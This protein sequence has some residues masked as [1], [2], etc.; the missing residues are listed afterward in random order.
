MATAGYAYLNTRV[1]VLAARLL[2]PERLETWVEA[3]TE[4]LARETG[5]T[6]IGELLRRGGGSTV[7]VEQA[8]LSML[9]ADLQ[10]LT[11][12]TGPADHKFLIYSIQWFELPNLK[13][14]FR[15]KF[16]G[17]SDQAIREHLVNT[18]PFTTLPVEQLLATEDPA[19]ML[20]VLENTP[21][22]DIARQARQ[23]YEQHKD[24]FSL[25]AAIDRRYL[26]GLH[27][28]ALKVQPGQRQATLNLTG[29]LVD[30]FNLLW[31]LRFR[32]S[33]NLSPA[34]TFFL[35]IPAGRRL[36]GDRLSAMA[37]LASLDEVLNALP[38]SVR[39]PLMGAAS[40]TEVENR[41][42]TEIGAMATR[43]LEDYRYPLARAF[44][45]LLLREIEMRSLMA[46]IKGRNLGF[47]PDLIRFATGHRVQ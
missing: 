10:V 17:L 3:G 9:L 12:P 46:I 25:D 37:Q 21:Y 18:S 33:Y 32:L 14:L 30:R 4:D 39:E 8:L 16:A 20:R 13:A 7:L 35:L 2:P 34:E 22:G 43:A 27:R 11:R 44:A 41:M 47:S 31:L 42:E 36:R 5:L 19:E 24:L 38:A 1:S 26:V 40:I 15:G 28:H 6:D 23:V 29:S 45:Y